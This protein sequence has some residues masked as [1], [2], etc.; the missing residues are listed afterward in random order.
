MQRLHHFYV[1]TAKFLF[2]HPQ[3]GI[4]SVRDPIRTGDASRYG[5][6]PIVLY[7][8]TVVGLPIRWTTFSDHEHR[9]PLR[10]VLFSA[11]QQGTGLRGQPDVVMVNRHLAQSDPTL[12]GDLA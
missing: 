1:A 2:H 6:T 12:I 5:L 11:W 3:C 10:E 9:L 4:V 7:G 8:L